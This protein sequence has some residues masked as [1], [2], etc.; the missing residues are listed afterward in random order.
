MVKQEPLKRRSEQRSWLS[1]ERDSAALELAISQNAGGLATT[2]GFLES[3]PEELRSLTL[4]EGQ[5]LSLYILGFGSFSSATVAAFLLM[6][7]PPADA[8]SL[9]ARSAV[10]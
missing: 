6:E 3:D 2:Q 10:G 4:D 9:S 7:T 8:S 1:S 5:S